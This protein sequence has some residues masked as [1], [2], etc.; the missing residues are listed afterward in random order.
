MVRLLAI[1]WNE[2]CHKQG[3][4]DSFQFLS[5]NQ[6]KFTR[7]KFN[8]NL[9]TIALTSGINIEK[10]SAHTIRHSFATHMLNRGSDLRCLQLLLGHA[11]ISSTQIYTKTRPE[12]L[13]GLLNTVHPL[14][15]N[16]KKD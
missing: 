12:R 1:K 10:V 11:D 2:L 5:E 6:R 8:K 13:S 3:S 7:Q 4:F 14:A 9:K 16:R 15:M